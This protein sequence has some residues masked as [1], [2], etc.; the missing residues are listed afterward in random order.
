MI[1]LENSSFIYI[2]SF[3]IIYNFCSLIFKNK[4]L[5]NILLLIGS[6]LI[7]G[8][9]CSTDSLAVVIGASILVYFGGKHLNKRTKNRKL[10]LGIFIGVLVSL[11]IIKNYNITELKPLS[12][13]GLS[14]ILFRLIHFLI[15]SNRNKITEYSFLSFINYVIFFPTFIAG[16]IDD[17]NN[18]NYWTKQKRNSYKITMLKAGGFRLLLGVLK[19]FFLVPI[20]INYSLDFSLFSDNI[21][22]Q[23]GFFTSLIFYSLYILFDFS[24]YSDIA[25]GTAYLIGIKTPENFDNPYFSKNLSIFWKKWHMTFSNFLFKY[26]FKPIVTGLSKYFPKSPRLLITF[27]GY[28]LTFIICG[29]WHGNTLNFLYWGIWHGIGL[30]IFKLWN[31]FIY[32]KYIEKVKAKA[33]HLIFNT[34]AMV[35]TFIFVTFGWFFFN[36]QSN[37]ISLITNNIT[38]KNNQSIIVST[39]IYNKTPIFRIDFSNNEYPFVDIEYKNSQSKESTT[40]FNIEANSNNIY[41]LMPD[42]SKKDIYLIRVRSSDGNKKGA[43]NTVVIYLDEKE[44]EQSIIEEYIF[45]EIPKSISLKQKPDY[46]NN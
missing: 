6:F 23:E 38:S 5:S 15:E 40:F 14:Y 16:P 2:L 13:L 31:I 10:Y 44:I 24:G 17:Y 26:I 46:V 43:W 30:I 35:I 9:I 19:K 4:T 11:F 7:L 3:I 27:T 33:F 32:K 41:Y 29:I 1:F 25:I 34:F 42:L 21:V 36:F 12:T 39:E 28:I 8:T 20:I 37:E 22:W 18:F 45:G